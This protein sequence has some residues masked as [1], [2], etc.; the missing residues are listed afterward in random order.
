MTEDEAV[1][2][3]QN[4]LGDSAVFKACSQV[5]NVQSASFLEACALDIQV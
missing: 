5:P 3:C 1:Q 2:Y 4:T